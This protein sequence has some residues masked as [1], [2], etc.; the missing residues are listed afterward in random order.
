MVF[1]KLF[2]SYDFQQFFMFSVLCH[3]SLLVNHHLQPPRHGGRQLLEVV[4]GHVLQSHLLDHLHQLGAE[5]M[6]WSS[7]SF[8]FMCDQQFSMGFKS[9]EFPGQSR[10]ENFSFFS[11]SIVILLRWQGALSCMKVFSL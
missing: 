8:L 6:V 9:G 2:F 5:V 10:I 4:P 7:F 1:K 3:L 11:T